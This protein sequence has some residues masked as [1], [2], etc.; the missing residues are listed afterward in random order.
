MKTLLTLVLLNCAFYINACGQAIQ[1]DFE[2]PGSLNEFIQLDNLRATES[3]SFAFKPG[4]GTVGSN[5]IV[6][7]KVPDGGITAL[8]KTGIDLVPGKTIT[9]SMDVHLV[10][11]LPA[12]NLLSIGVSDGIF[13]PLA[14]GPKP[15]PCFSVRI[16]P[17]QNTGS[18]AI[19]YS[20]VGNPDNLREFKWIKS[21]EVGDNKPDWI[22]LTLA[23][24]PESVEGDFRFVVSA[25]TLGASGGDSP[26]PLAEAS[27][28]FKN[29]PLSKQKMLY[30]GFRLDLG[31]AVVVA[32]NFKVSY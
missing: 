9:L 32:D 12:G 28:T 20:N 14:A 3:K 27:G 11:P 23:I 17:A 24:T 6:L 8:S 30:P 25:A 21:M 18:L 22:R 29:E 10:G 2:S 13:S 4:A 16:Q 7:E 5:A 15:K 26:A 19:F 1:A 31:E